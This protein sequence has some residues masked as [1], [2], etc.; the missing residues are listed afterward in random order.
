VGGCCLLSLKLAATELQSIVGN[1]HAE[2]RC[3]AG[4][5]GCPVV[6]ATASCHWSMTVAVAPT[7]VQSMTAC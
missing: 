5:D 1:G 7:A 3:V 6:V 2:Q 4:P